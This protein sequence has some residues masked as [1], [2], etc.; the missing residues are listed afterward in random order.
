MD[1]ENRP[2]TLGQVVFVAA[3]KG[4]LS[5]IRAACCAAT[6]SGTVENVTHAASCCNID[7][8]GVCL[9]PLPIR[10]L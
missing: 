6:L 10:E 3:A 9:Y 2:G 8:A 7:L 5:C 1:K 4:S